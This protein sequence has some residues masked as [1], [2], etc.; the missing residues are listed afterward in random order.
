[1]AGKEIAD[2]G[3]GVLSPSLSTKHRLTL[4]TTARG[5]A[6]ATFTVREKEIQR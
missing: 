1:V 4:K 5:W 3:I 2:D 6:R